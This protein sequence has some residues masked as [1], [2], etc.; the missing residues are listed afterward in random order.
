MLMQLI[1]MVKLNIPYA[2]A[3]NYNGKMKYSLC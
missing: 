2:D 3:A 1:T